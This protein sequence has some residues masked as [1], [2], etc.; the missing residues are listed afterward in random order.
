M[1]AFISEI[2]QLRKIKKLANNFY[3]VR[4]VD[5]LHVSAKTQTRS[6]LFIIAYIMDYLY[7]FLVGNKVHD[8]WY[9]AYPLD[10]TSHVLRS[11][12][13]P[14]FLRYAVFVVNVS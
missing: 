6:S 10:H 1:P 5:A 8:L 2:S 4:S 14:H 12:R 11:V 13:R 7:V 9:D 3:L